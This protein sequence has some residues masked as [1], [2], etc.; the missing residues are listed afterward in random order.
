MISL[1]DFSDLWDL[2]ASLGLKYGGWP[3]EGLDFPHASWEIPG[4]AL[5]VYLTLVFGQNF[6]ILTYAH[7]EKVLFRM[8]LL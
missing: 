5:T 4:E 8:A 3:A 2:I 1:S 6:M 7:L